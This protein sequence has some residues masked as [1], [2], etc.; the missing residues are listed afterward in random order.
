VCFDIMDGKRKVVGGALRVTKNAMLYQ[1]NI[2]LKE[3]D[4]KDLKSLKT[5]L[6]QCLSNQLEDDQ[7]VIPAKAGTCL[8]GRRVQRLLI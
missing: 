2:V 6:F 4:T 3:S 7:V 1:G 8:A 5:I